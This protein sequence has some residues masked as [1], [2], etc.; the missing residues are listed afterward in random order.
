MNN[1]HI[2]DDDSQIINDNIDGSDAE[3]WE[4]VSSDINSNT[5]IDKTKIN[6]ISTKQKT[7]K[8]IVRHCK[9]RKRTK[10]SS[11]KSSNTKQVNDD[12]VNFFQVIHSIQNDIATMSKNM[13]RV[14]EINDEVMRAIKSTDENEINKKLHVIVNETNKAATKAKTSIHMLKKEN[15]RLEKEGLV[16][17]SDL[18]IRENLYNATLNKFVDVTKKCKEA[19]EQYKINLKKKVSRNIRI[20]I[21]DASDNDIDMIIKSGNCERENVYQQVILGNNASD[22]IRSMLQSV[23]QKYEDI[24]LLE[25]HI[26]ELHQMYLDFSLLTEHQGEVLDHIEYQVKIANDNIEEGNEN[27]HEGIKY[28]KKIRKKQGIIVGIVVVVIIIIVIGIL[29]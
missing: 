23:S 22:V 27:M 20:L 14:M 9:L 16:R 12:M 28:Q 13:K 25:Q 18:R 17:S 15:V 3:S 6:S 1:I 5:N 26:S 8:R 24:L 11:K 4:M 10:H 2:F 19:E 7:W 21:P 29:A